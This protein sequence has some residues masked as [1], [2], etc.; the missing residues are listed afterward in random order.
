MIIYFY[1]W[2]DMIWYDT[3]WVMSGLAWEGS[4]FFLVRKAEC[5]SLL[6]SM[7]SLPI[8][9]VSRYAFSRTTIT[10]LVK[11]LMVNILLGAGFSII[12]CWN[13]NVLLVLV[14]LFL[15][16]MQVVVE[17]VQNEINIIISMRIQYWKA[18]TNKTNREERRR[19]GKETQQQQTRERGVSHC[20]NTHCCVI[21]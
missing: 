20:V 2:Y 19:E 8:L 4:L 9:A 3:W 10:P 5:S 21:I 14:D 18:Q 1:E 12:C 6:R 16:V 15:S 17:M 13:Y 7:Y 11:F